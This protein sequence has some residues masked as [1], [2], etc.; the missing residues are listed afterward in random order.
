MALHCLWNTAA[1]ISGFGGP[2]PDG[3]ELYVSAGAD[4]YH[5]LVNV[6]LVTLPRYNTKSATGPYFGLGARR[7]VSR[8]QDLGV[9]LEADDISGRTLLSVRMLDYR[10]RFNS[11]LAFN[12]FVGGSRYAQATPAYGVYAGAGLQWRNVLP[13]WDVGLD[14]RTVFEAQRLRDLPTDPE[15]LGTVKPDAFVNIYSWTL[16]LT[17]TF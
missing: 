15:P 17:R 9:A 10:Y 4:Y 3:D 13:G 6:N 14:Y 5:S 16:H 8:H 11:P 12:V 2:R 7:R 1:T